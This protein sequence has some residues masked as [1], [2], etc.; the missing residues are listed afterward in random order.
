MRNRSGDYAALAAH[1]NPD[2]PV[3]GA[4]Q[5]DEAI[6][7]HQRARHRPRNQGQLLRHIGFLLL[8]PADMIL[9]FHLLLWLDPIAFEPFFGFIRRVPLWTAL[10][11]VALSTWLVM[12]LSI[13]I[14]ARSEQKLPQPPQAISEWLRTHDYPYGI[15]WWHE[16]QWPWQKRRAHRREALGYVLWRTTPLPSQIQAND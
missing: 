8:L 2:D 14:E 9:A 3:D 13:R 15:A 16:T 1:L 7:A 6:L 5:I 10:P 11:I 12:F 4:R